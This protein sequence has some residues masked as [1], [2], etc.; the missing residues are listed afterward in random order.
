MCILDVL[1][2]TLVLCQGQKS[3]NNQVG[4]DEHKEKKFERTVSPTKSLNLH[5]VL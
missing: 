2:N 4:V 1:E 5:S 3:I